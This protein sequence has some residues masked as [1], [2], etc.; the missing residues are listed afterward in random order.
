MAVKT[1]SKRDRERKKE[2]L[3]QQY[4]GVTNEEQTLL[5]PDVQILARMSR[6]KKENEE[7]RHLFFRG[8]GSLTPSPKNTKFQRFPDS[9]NAFSGCNICTSDNCAA[10]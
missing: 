1:D 2:K 8:E 3:S 10:L 5:F 7:S 4:S 6:F 9:N